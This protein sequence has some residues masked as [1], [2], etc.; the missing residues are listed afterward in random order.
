MA[1]TKLTS[2]KILGLNQR[3]Y[4]HL[5]LTFSLNLRRQLLMAVCDDIVLQKRLATQLEA[6]LTEL[7]HPQNGVS[8][9]EKPEKPAAAHPKFPKLVR[10][11][12]NPEKPDF[13]YTDCP[14]GETTQTPSKKRS[15]DYA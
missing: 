14:V 12:L 8:A 4:Q 10:L 1:V 6:D 9:A 5:K 7:F 13:A 11:V 2:R 3:T 15:L